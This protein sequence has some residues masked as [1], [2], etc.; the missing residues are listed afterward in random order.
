MKRR[1]AFAIVG[2]SL[3]GLAI[4]SFVAHV[5]WQVVSGHGGD[6]YYN[7][8]YQ[9]M[10]YWGALGSMGIMALVGLLGLFH[11]LK[12]ALEDRRNRKT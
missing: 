2:F 8:K 12:R 6:T 9:P 10:T 1:T 5:L 4:A 3:F 7:Y 11:R